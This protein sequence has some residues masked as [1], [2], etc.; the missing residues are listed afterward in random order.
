MQI[1]DSLIMKLLSL[2][3][4]NDQTIKINDPNGNII[5]NSD[6]SLEARERTR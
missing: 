1:K 3:K 5:V 2:L 6:P 4:I